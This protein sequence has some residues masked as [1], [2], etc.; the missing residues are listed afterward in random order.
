[1]SKSVLKVIFKTA[2]ECILY[3]FFCVVLLY[4][5]ALRMDMGRFSL[6]EDAFGAWMLWILCIISIATAC[7][8]FF[9][10]LFIKKRWTVNII[11]YSLA[12]VVFA[13]SNIIADIGF[14]RFENFTTEKWV[15]Y[16]LQRSTMYYDFVEKY[17][18]I[19][20]TADEIESLLGKPDEISEANSYVYATSN[21]AVFVK[22][23]DGKATDISHWN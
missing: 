12:I 6:Y 22:F 2:V 8:I 19:G 14:T 1:M 23:E 18:I 7:S 3:W 5:L 9:L 16:P 11:A 15:A 10:R 13:S 17:D 20:K 4:I 21:N